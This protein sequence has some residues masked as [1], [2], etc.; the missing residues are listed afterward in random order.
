MSD[1]PSNQEDVVQTYQKRSTH[2]DSSVRLFD[3]FRSFG[4]DI[5]A[6][7]QAAVKALKLEPGDTVIDIGCGT[8]M[9]FPFLYKE[10]G[11]KGKIIGVDLS[12]S[13]LEQAHQS[14]LDNG[15]QNVELVCSDAT[16][17]SFPPNVDAILST[18]ALILVPECGRVVANG[19]Q[20][21]RSGGRFSIFDMCWPEGWSFHWRH[22]LFFLRSY[23]VTH[24][25]LERRP[26][27]TIWRTMEENLAN[28]SRQMYWF[29]M[30]YLVS[31]ERQPD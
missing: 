4:F 28:V 21:L 31:G 26:W 19:C 23:G 16:I 9:N 14:A 25:T 11:P 3:L 18:F 17:Y 27:Q 5:P 13:M 24:E 1:T 15:W 20:A 6:W 30:M 12:E 7:R 10:I 2:Y 29:R 8:G 22:L